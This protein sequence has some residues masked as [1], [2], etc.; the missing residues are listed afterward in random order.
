ML[1]LGKDDLCT[2][3]TKYYIVYAKVAALY[4]KTLG[5]EGAEDHGVKHCIYP[6]CLE[7]KNA[8]RL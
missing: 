7:Y 3:S 8:F 5:S 6:A 2:T 4:E 1:R